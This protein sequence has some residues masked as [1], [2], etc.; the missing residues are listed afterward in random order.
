M[1]GASDEAI[2][3]RTCDTGC[4]LVTGTFEVMLRAKDPARLLDLLENGIG[5]AKAFGC[6]WLDAGAPSMTACSRNQVP[7]HC[8]AYA[9]H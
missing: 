6:G 8:I 7:L 4:C 5:P 1:H 9:M 3:T 2:L